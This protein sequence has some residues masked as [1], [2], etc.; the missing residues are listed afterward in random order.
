M[1]VLGHGVVA[2]GLVVAGQAQQVADA[3]GIGAQQVALDGDAV[4]VAAGHLD[5]G[6][7]AQSQQHG[8][9]GDGGHAHHGGLVV[10]DVDRVDDALQELGLVLD[11]SAVGALRWAQLAGGGKVA[12]LEAFSRLLPTR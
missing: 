2:K 4:A 11:H 6:L 7:D 3:Q 12:G 10:G 9:D 5:G 1:D 8:R